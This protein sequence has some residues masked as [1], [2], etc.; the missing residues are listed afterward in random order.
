MRRSPHSLAASF[1]YAGTGLLELV[2]TQR[3]ARIEL[4]VGAIAIALAVA[5]GVTPP[6]W[7]ILVLTIALVVI[8]EGMNTVLELTV[9]LASPE[10]NP[11]AK[12]AKDITAGMVLVA[13]AASIGVGAAILL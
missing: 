10:R 7:A 11:A 4:A 9:D 13:A 12:A 3:N 1:R 8:L 6:E 2:R 5:L